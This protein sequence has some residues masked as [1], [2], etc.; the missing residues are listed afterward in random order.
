MAWLGELDARSGRKAGRTR[1]FTA[2]QQRAAAL[3]EKR[4]ESIAQSAPYHAASVPT[5]L[6]AACNVSLERTM[7]RED[8][9]GLIIFRAS[10][11]R[12]AIAAAKSSAR[13]FPRRRHPFPTNVYSKATKRHVHRNVP[14]TTTSVERHGLHAMQHRS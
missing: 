8:V 4:A 14:T 11:E 3:V 7:G 10:P 9:G 1:P 2:R 13:R 12:S 5:R 6:K